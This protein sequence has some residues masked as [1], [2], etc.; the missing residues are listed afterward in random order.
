MI[1]GSVSIAPSFTK[2]VSEP[3][4]FANL[5]ISYGWKGILL[6]VFFQAL[7]VVIAIIPG[8]VV[9][10]A[11]G[12]IYGTFA[13]TALSILGIVAG[14]AII[15]FITRIFGY[16][17]VK[18]FVSKKN[19]EKLDFI[20]NGQKSEFAM[21]ILFLIPGFPKDLLTYVAGLTPVHPGKFFLIIFIARL[22]ALIASSYIGA[23]LQDKNYVVVI[24]LSV[25][26]V[27]LFTAGVLLREKL[28]TLMH[29][30]TNKHKEEENEI[31]AD[32]K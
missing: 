12:Y 14:S 29:R 19:L 10:I 6:F 28:F 25:I 4:E 27:I 26:A 1:Y 15:F 18:A 24:V 9:Q 2:L 8:E 3:E 31:K 17:V 16:P 32:K 30:F 22:P 13:G 7:Q 23:N 5:I 11:G 21:F 20:I